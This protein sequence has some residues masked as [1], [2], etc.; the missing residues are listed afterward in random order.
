MDRSTAADLWRAVD[1]SGALLLV[2]AVSLQ[3]LGLSLGGNDLPWSSPWVLGALGASLALFG[4]FIRVEGRTRAIP[5]IP[6]RMLRGKLPVLTQVANVCG[7][8]AAYA[9]SLTR[10]LLASDTS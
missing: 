9:V 10:P 6:L 1:F 8:T 5:M 7:G 2:A 3:L 4:L